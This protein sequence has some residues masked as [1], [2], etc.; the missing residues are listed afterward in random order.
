MVVSQYKGKCGRGT[1]PLLPLVRSHLETKRCTFATQNENTT[2]GSGVGEWEKEGG[3]LYDEKC[4]DESFFSVHKKGHHAS[5]S[6]R[7]TSS[8]TCVKRYMRLSWDATASVW[9][10]PFAVMM[11]FFAYR[12]RTFTLSPAAKPN[13]VRSTSTV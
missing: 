1:Y 5:T 2:R 4:V 12:S 3:V 6:C 10:D 8:V 11:S 13:S 7:S 9:K